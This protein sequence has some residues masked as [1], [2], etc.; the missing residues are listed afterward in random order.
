MKS[1]SKL[2]LFSLIACVAAISSAATWVST[3]I[4]ETND[5]VYIGRTTADKI[6]FHGVT[7]VIQRAGS[8]QAAVTQTSAANAT[9]AATDLTTSE[10]LANAL[11]TQGNALVV[12]VAALTVLVNELRAA[13]VQKGLIKGG[14]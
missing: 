5:S 1:K 3:K 8:A 9:A 4:Y 6:G 13:D 12:D 2:L 14:S 7:A 11:K 10:A